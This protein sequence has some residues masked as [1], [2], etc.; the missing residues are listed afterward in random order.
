MTQH[1]F[2]LA[3][4]VPPHSMHSGQGNVCEQ[5]GPHRLLG[6]RPPV[7]RCVSHHAI[8]RLRK[9]STLRELCLLAWVSVIAAQNANETP[10]P[11]PFRCYG[12]RGARAYSMPPRSPSSYPDAIPCQANDP[13]RP[14]VRGWGPVDPPRRGIMALTRTLSGEGPGDGKAWY[15]RDQPSRP[16]SVGGD[17]R[18]RP[19]PFCHTCGGCKHQKGGARARVDGR[20]RAS[21][22][23]GLR[24][25][26]VALL[27]FWE[28]AAYRPHAARRSS[29]AGGSSPSGLPRTEREYILENNQQQVK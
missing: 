23:G 18:G 3:N 27:L 1:T 16:P 26:G 14:C 29:A 11:C 9:A 13:P 4:R 20:T 15:G 24:A 7:A 21:G 19:G 25:R 5:I 12:P 28:V 10:M 6:G 8:L 22:A 2:L 17:G